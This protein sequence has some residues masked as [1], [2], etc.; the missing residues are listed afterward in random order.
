[1]KHFLKSKLTLMWALLICAVA[2]MNAQTWTWTGE[3]P[4]AGDFYIRSNVNDVFIKATSAVDANPANATLFTLSAATNCTIAYQDN[5]TKYVYESAGNQSWGTTNT[6]KW[7]IANQ[8]NNN[9]YYISQ[10][11]PGYSRGTRTRYI[12]VSASAINYPYQG[13]TGSN[14]LL[15]FISP[16]QMTAYNNYIAAWNAL[17][18]VLA[19]SLFHSI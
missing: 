18:P 5:G 17:S 2:Q 12:Q 14:R 9:Q 15:M 1:M 7:T 11:D 16:A 3:A 8:N 19:R 4:A 13:F 6:N 10:T